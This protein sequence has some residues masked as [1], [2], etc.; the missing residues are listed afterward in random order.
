MLTPVDDLKYQIY[1]IIVMMIGMFV[2]TTFISLIKSTIAEYSTTSLENIKI[3][4]LELWLL[5]RARGASKMV[6]DQQQMGMNDKSLMLEALY[7]YISRIVRIDSKAMLGYHSYINQISPIYRQKI[8]DSARPSIQTALQEDLSLGASE[9]VEEEFNTK[10]YVLHD[11]IIMLNEIPQKL[12]VV[13][14]GEVGVFLENLLV[15][16]LRNGDM[17]GST[18]VLEKKSRL[19]LRVTNKYSYIWELP[20]TRLSEVYTKISISD[21]EILLR[22]LS[23]LA[24]KF[25]TFY[26]ESKLLLDYMPSRKKNDFRSDTLTRARARRTGNRVR[27][28]LSMTENE[29]S[30]VRSRRERSLSNSLEQIVEQDSQ[31]SSQRYE[32]SSN[33]LKIS[34]T[35]LVKDLKK[36][37][38]KEKNSPK[39]KD[40]RKSQFHEPFNFSFTPGFDL[41]SDL[42]VFATREWLQEIQPTDSSREASAV[43][44]LHEKKSKDKDHPTDELEESLGEGSD[45]ESSMNSEENNLN[46]SETNSIERPPDDIEIKLLGEYEEK[47]EG[48]MLRSK[49]YFMKTI[50]NLNQLSHSVQKMIVQENLK[51]QQ[52]LLDRSDYEEELNKTQKEGKDWVEKTQEKTEQKRQYMDQEE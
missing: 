36:P 11:E 15:R 30:K 37:S 7:L 23:S 20:V 51:S 32:S 14:E 9:M 31:E 12:F 41:T 25:E 44:I 39:S 28:I 10:L 2:I 13:K 3:E 26:V 48:L 27:S 22:N 6:N 21:R 5:T 29:I 17:F 35:S 19:S 1:S 8:K 47:L 33:L 16:T 40:P 50:K 42:R 38:E 4:E 18:A 49:K 43:N 46:D 34:V 52:S 24:K 45:D